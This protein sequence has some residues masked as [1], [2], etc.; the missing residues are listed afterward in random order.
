MPN[1]VGYTSPTVQLRPL[2][3]SRQQL[4]N[5]SFWPNERIP[6][7]PLVAGTLSTKGPAPTSASPCLSPSLPLL[8]YLSHGL[9]YCYCIITLPKCNLLKHALTRLLKSGAKKK[10]LQLKKKK[11]VRIDLF[12]PPISLTY[13]QIA[14]PV[15]SFKNILTR[16]FVLN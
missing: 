8:P 10:K 4:M 1:N 16:E 3:P 15:P 9:L 5:A 2:H 12:S 13:I 14:R 7:S 6:Y 11:Q